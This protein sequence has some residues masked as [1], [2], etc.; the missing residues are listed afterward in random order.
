VKVTLD[1]L[2]DQ[3][4]KIGN[5]SDYTQVIEPHSEWH[6]KALLTNPKAAHA[7][8]TAVEEQK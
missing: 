1:L 8:V 3:D 4:Q 5:A 6:F 2:D 7:K